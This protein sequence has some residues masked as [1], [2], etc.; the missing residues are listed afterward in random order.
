MVGNFVGRQ[1]FLRRILTVNVEPERQG[2]LFIVPGIPGSGK[3]ELLDQLARAAEKREPGPVSTAIYIH[4]DDYAVLGSRR[5]T[6]PPDEATDLRHFKELLQAHFSGMDRGEAATDAA[7]FAEAHPGFG[8]HL[9]TRSLT[10]NDTDQLIDLA[11]KGVTAL[12]RN[13]AS[14]QERL[15]VLVDDFHLL[16]WRPLGDWVLR[17]LVA[18]KG[19]DVAISTL[20][21]RAEHAPPWPSHAIML[22]LGNLSRDDVQRYLASSEHV[23]PDVA[24]KIVG[25]VWEFTGGNPQ[26]LVLVADLFRE[27]EHPSDAVQTIRQVGALDGKLAEKL[28]ELVERIF[29]AIDDAGLQRALYSL[30]VT[31][32][33]DTALV[34]QLLGVDQ[35][36]AGTLVNQMRQFSF[37]A[38]ADDRNFLTIRPYVRRLGEEKHTD[39]SQRAEIHMAAAEYFH[40]LIR[41]EMVEDQSW[42]NAWYRLEDKQFQFHKKEWLYHVSR[43]TGARRRTGRLEIARLFLDSFWWWGCYVPFPFCEEIL[44]DWMSATAGEKE[45]RDWGEALQG[46]YNTYPRGNRLDRATRSQ[47]ITVRGY[48]HRL[49]GRSTS[50]TQQHNAD[51]RHVR[52]VVDFFLADVLRYIDPADPHVDKA[53]ADAT[54]LLAEDDDYFVAWIDVQRS[55][56]NVQRGQWEEAMSLARQGAQRH[57]K[58]NDHE[59]IGNF[60]RIHAD[61][62]WACGKA[63]Q[64]LDGYARA[65]LHAYAAQ[66]Q[67]SPD[68]FTN[69]FQQEMMDRCLER[70]AGLHAAADDSD[71]A[72]A[73]L[74]SACRRIRAFFGAYWEAIGEDEAAD[75]TTNVVR[76]LADCAPMEAAS[77]LFPALAPEVDTGLSRV[78]TRWDFICDSVLGEMRDDLEALPGTPLSPVA[79]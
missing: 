53:L 24:A 69:A 18:I 12:A 20:P 23:G 8:K 45:D 63:E 10:E 37:V 72:L 76:A 54:A 61:A 60:H 4:G 68:S 21:A 55:D 6:R 33:F 51:A 39:G 11:T 5:G 14:R 28:E 66:V 29:R 75:V 62:L 42:A 64:A 16:A 44:S 67:V 30:C 26:A 70:M 31:R 3:T 7:N 22:P 56:L 43:L 1:D 46:L 57:A 58:Y 40:G 17:W 34:M 41:K 74:L 25:P 49:R 35:V 48:L 2:R 65:V 79:D 52:G 19:A 47:L 15:L 13:L 36:Q 27:S 38:E 59:L 78:A 77:V 9:R 50:G 32:Y 73:V 71:G